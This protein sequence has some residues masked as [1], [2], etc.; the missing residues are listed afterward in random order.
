MLILVLQQAASGAVTGVARDTTGATIGQTDPAGGATIDAAGNL[1][2]LRIKFTA[3][4]NA[5][6]ST[7]AG[8]M[9]P[10]LTV[11]AT[12]SNTTATFNGVPINGLG[13]TLTP[14]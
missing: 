14:P 1:R 4:S 6:D 10:S 3:A 9:Q 8:Q 2:T 13:V 5:V 7:L 11:A 12:V